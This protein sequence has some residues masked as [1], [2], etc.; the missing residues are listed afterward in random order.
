[1]LILVLFYHVVIV[2][3]LENGLNYRG[4]DGSCPRSEVRFSKM[5]SILIQVMVRYQVLGE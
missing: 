3:Q 5:A 1:M 2:I 4:E